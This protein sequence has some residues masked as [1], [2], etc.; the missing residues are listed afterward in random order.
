MCTLWNKYLRFGY[1]VGGAV[2]DS[3]TLLW[4]SYSTHENEKKKSN[5]YDITNIQN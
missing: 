3:N 1:V 5:V 2:C 4:E